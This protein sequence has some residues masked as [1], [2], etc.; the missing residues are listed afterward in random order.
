V[1]T[2]FNFVLDFEPPPLTP[3]A[4]LELVPL[5]C[6]L[7]YNYWAGAFLEPAFSLPCLALAVWVGF[8]LVF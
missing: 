4:V 3:I 5:G 2:S 6:V 8:I 7:V 1:L